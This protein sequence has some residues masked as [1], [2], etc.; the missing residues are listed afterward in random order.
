MTQNI[1]V[2]GAGPGLGMGVA[3]AFGRQG[4]G[5]GLISRNGESLETRAAGLRADGV[6]AVAAPADVRDPA[7]LTGALDAIAAELGPLT[8]VEYGPDPGAA[9]ITS[10]EATTA[11]A[12]ADQFEL[13]VH[14][15]LRA[16]RHVLPEMV[17]RG[18][19]AILVTTGASAA[20]PMPM[21][22]SVGI[23]MSGLRN[24]ALSA[25]AELRRSGVYVGTLMVATTVQP[26]GEGDPDR[27]GDL[28]YD[29][30]AK[31][32][33]PEEVVGDLEAVRDLVDRHYGG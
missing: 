33:R 32:D 18:D 29:M 7:A 5:I 21:L 10:A 11:E 22:G 20:L 31:R 8:V 27:I 24:W 15:A 4:F 9:A 17:A 30:Q 23:A 12:A 28:Y 3:R 13:V 6:R 19:G 16:A 14:G 2:I 1:A 26:G 25:N